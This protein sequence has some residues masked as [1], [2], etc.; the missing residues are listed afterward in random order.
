MEV[1]NEIRAA[2]ACPALD[3]FRQQFGPF[4]GVRFE[5]RKV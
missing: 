3:S 5:P 2:D 1:L 4:Y